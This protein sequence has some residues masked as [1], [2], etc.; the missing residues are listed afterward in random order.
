MITLQES[1]RIKTTPSAFMKFWE[2]LE[3]NYPFMH[4]K[5]HVWVKCMKAKPTQ[6]GCVWEN[7]EY[8]GGKHLVN[9]KYRVVEVIPNQRIVSKLATF[10]GC[11]MRTL[12]I[13]EIADHGH[14]IQVTE[15]TSIG[16]DIP[17]LGKIVDAIVNK[18]LAPILPAV[19]AHEAEGLAYIKDWLETQNKSHKVDRLTDP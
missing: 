15:T 5:D 17:I 13:L 1:I 8:I 7:K 16:Y 18:G 14:E 4:P 9:E 3:E 10:P 11:L 2:D 19:K 12:L 6:V